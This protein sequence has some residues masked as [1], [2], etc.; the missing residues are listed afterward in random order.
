[1]APGRSAQIRGSPHG[2]PDVSRGRLGR[3][4][5]LF[6]N[7]AAS[8]AY[9][10]RNG[11]AEQIT[12]R[13]WS[14][15]QRRPPLQGAAAGALRSSCETSQATKGDMAVG[16][17]P[18]PPGPTRPQGCDACRTSPS[19]RPSSARR[20]PPRSH[21]RGDRRPTGT[22]EAM[23]L[24]PRAQ[25]SRREG[26]PRL[27]PSCADRA[28]QKGCP[29]PGSR[30]PSRECRWSWRSTR[31]SPTSRYP[32]QWGRSR[33]VSY[34]RWFSREPLC[35]DFAEQIASRAVR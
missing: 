17:M 15:K 8:L 9:N 3:V 32:E 24:E 23:S 22:R 12:V 29:R 14:A 13:R 28:D 20:W 21:R 5:T 27:R 19:H 4:P 30:R 1:M 6:G 25:G 34:R 26:S 2:L 18:I 16:A 11:V 35:D 7:L 10:L 33:T 31:R